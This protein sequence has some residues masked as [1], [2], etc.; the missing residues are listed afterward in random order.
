[1]PRRFHVLVT[2]GPT[3]EYLDPVRYLSNDSSGQMGFALARAAVHLGFRATLVSGPVSLETPKGVRRIDVVSAREMRTA[4]LK[5]AP[6]ADLIVMCAAVADYRPKRFSRGKIKKAVSRPYDL[7]ITLTENADILAELGRGKKPHQT[8]VG[9][10]L[11]THRLERNA[12][13]KMQRKHCDWIVANAASTIGARVGRALL[14]NRTGRRIPL[15]RL[16]KD[17]LAIVILS[18]IAS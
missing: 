4:V 9:F 15:P 8:L 16:P 17:D 2:A 11:E 14:L 12:R 18:H 10:A 1:M 7:T 6:R 3:R 5:Q 13:K